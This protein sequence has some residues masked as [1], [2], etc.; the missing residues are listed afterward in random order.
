MRQHTE[1]SRG[2]G[3]NAEIIVEGQLLGGRGGVVCS[4]LDLPQRL[5]L[6]GPRATMAG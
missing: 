4:F 1:L 5:K 6:D 2:T 3:S